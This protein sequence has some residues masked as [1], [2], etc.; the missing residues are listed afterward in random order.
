MSES[1]TIEAINTGPVIPAISSEDHQVGHA[2]RVYL[3]RLTKPVGSLGRIETLATRLATIAGCVPGPLLQ[4]PALV[5]FAGDHGVVAEGVTH[6]P[7]DVTAQMV[8]NFA[9]GGAAINAITDQ[10]GIEL[11]VV[12]VGVAG[13]V[14]AV[15]GIRHNKVRRGTSNLAVEPAM[16][17]DEAT[18]AFEVGLSIAYELVDK[19]CDLLATGE[20]GIGNTTSAAAIICMLTGTPA[21]SGVGRGTGI[22]DA[23]FARKVS[24]VNR[25]VDRVRATGSHLDDPWAVLSNLGGFE[26]AAL[27]GF[28]IGGASRSVPVVLDGVITLAAAMIA[29]RLD[30]NV[31]HHLIAGHRS[32]E[33]AAGFTLDFLDIDPILELDMRLGEGTGAAMA[34]PIVQAAAALMHRMA[35]FDAAGVTDKS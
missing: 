25:A 12:D 32:T 6:W 30:Q 14:S 7:S 35:T 8:A 13:D 27:A 17:H 24:V 19:G 31:R 15:T 11:M 21:H 28:I 10:F 9:A 33:P 1:R 2:A 26:I 5:V 16:S 20:M 23:T 4:H 18:A 22:D 34:I 29:D 3:S